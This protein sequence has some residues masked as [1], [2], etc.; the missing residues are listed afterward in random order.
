[1]SINHSSEMAAFLASGG[2]IKRLME[3]EAEDILTV[4]GWRMEFISGDDQVGYTRANID[5]D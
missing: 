4:D 1:M 3:G 5:N 2:K